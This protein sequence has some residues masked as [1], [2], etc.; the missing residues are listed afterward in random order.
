MRS[1]GRFKQKAM[2][3][4]MPSFTDKHRMHFILESMRFG[5]H[6]KSPSPCCYPSSLAPAYQHCK[7]A[8][9]DG[10]HSPHE[11]AIHLLTLRRQSMRN[12]GRLDTARVR[13]SSMQLKCEERINH[14]SK[15][16]HP[17]SRRCNRPQTPWR[18]R[19]LQ[20]GDEHRDGG[21]LT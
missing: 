21:V 9:L 13:D 19:V 12:V 6:N 8:Y 15:R 16:L 4:R 1:A 20:G 17:S 10:K 14:R 7:S 5:R 2:R 3:V 18:S 11:W